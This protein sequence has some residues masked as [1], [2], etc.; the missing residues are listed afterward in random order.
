M[1]KEIRPVPLGADERRRPGFSPAGRTKA[2]PT[3]FGVPLIVVLLS[4][5]L[6]GCSFFSRSQSRFYSLEKIP[7]AAPVANV[8]G[9]PIGI[10]GVELP[11][12]FDR[13]EVV[14]RKPDHQL[15]VRATQQWSATLGQS[16]LHTLAFDLAGRLPEG[17]VILPGSAKANGPM[18]AIDVAF[19]ELAAGPEPKVVLDAR[20][21]VRE[22]GRPDVTRHERIAIDIASLDSANI[23]SGISQALAALAD[24]IVAGLS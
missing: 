23:A 5:S 4:L 19:E 17:T 10:D 2:R 21:I 6:S 1:S 9:V 15:D 7:P 11:P 24:R 8:R 20:W 16:V 3:S 18:R 12:G 13:R 22:A 14:V